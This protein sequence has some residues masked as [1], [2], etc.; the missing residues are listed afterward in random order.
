MI[1]MEFKSERPVFPYEYYCFPTGGFPLEAGIYVSFGRNGTLT[2]MRGVFFTDS[3]GCLARN[4][5]DC[6]LYLALDY[7]PRRLKKY[8]IQISDGMLTIWYGVWVRRSIT[9]SLAHVQAVQIR[10]RPAQ[11]LFGLCSIILSLPGTRLVLSE[12]ETVSCRTFL[13]TVRRGAWIGP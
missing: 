13:R 3:F 7:A 8:R 10:R 5:I 1:K 4:G 6:I 9:I 2:G 12:L 11:R